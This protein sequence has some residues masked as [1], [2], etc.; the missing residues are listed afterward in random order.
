[1]AAIDLNCDLGEGGENDA[2][3]MPL[4]SSANIAC[5]AHAGDE[6]SMRTAV[7]LA[8]QCGVVIGAHPGWPDRA[9]MGRAELSI[10]PDAVCEIVAEQIRRLQR[11]CGEERAA[12]RYV[13]PHGALYNAAARDDRVAHAVAAAVVRVDRGLALVGL[14][15][16]RS[17]AAAVACGLRAVPEAFADR[18][19]QAD[20]TLTPRSQPDALISDPQRAAE[21]AVQLATAGRVRALGGERIAITAHTL[22]VHGDGRGAVAVAAQVR[23]AL[24]AAG[25]EIRAFCS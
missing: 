21:Q 6:Q 10:D 18:T 15:G 22:C 13:K 17:L 7:R 11:V 23:A 19:Y 12:L 5:G 14:A 9:A 2:A 4:I 1:M 3:L 16:G 25:V 24:I 20:G 8:L